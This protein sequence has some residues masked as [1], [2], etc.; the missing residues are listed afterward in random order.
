MTHTVF[1]K[2]QT[3]PLLQKVKDCHRIGESHLEI[4]PDSL[5]QM[6]QFAD[7]REEREERFYEHSVVPLPTLAKFQVTRL[8]I[9]RA[10]S[11]VCQNNHLLV[12][13]SDHR[14]KF[15]VG[16]IGGLDLPI[17]HQSEFVRQHTK[18]AANYPFPRGKT[19]S[20]D[21]LSV[22]LMN[23]ADRMAQFNTVR[24]NDTE[25]GRLAQKLRRQFP[26]SFQTAEKSGSLRQIRKQFK[27]VVFEPPIKGS[28]RNTFQSEQQS[29]RQKFTSGKFS[30]RMFLRFRQHIIYTTKKFYDKV[31]LSHGF[32]SPCEWFRHLHNK[33]FSV[34]FSTSTNG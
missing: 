23:L 27:P 33:N 22:R 2:V 19:F 10:K 26:M 31:F 1:I 17:R 4:C 9:F 12:N 11:L 34:T 32:V 24:V 30:L 7:L 6:F 21:A 13:R 8:I 29:E 14:Q 20:A 28:L 16:N 5:P 3:I 15:L 25:D 18:F